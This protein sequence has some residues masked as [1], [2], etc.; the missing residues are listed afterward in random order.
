M[1]L[2]RSS[3]SPSVQ[4]N[5]S[6]SQSDTTPFIPML[7]EVSEGYLLSPVSS[8]FRRPLSGSAEPARKAFSTNSNL[9]S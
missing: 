1:C 5:M 7:I 6:F 4:I 2:P 3:Y 9:A 8:I